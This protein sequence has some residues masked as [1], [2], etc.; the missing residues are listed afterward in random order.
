MLNLVSKEK[1]INDALKQNAD[2]NV[3]T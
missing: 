1:Q 3:Q 2:E